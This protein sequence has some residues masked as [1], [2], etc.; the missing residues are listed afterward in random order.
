MEYKNKKMVKN[1]SKKNQELQEEVKK[2]KLLILKNKF[3][4][5]NNHNNSSRKHQKIAMQ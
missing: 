2:I 4:F 3:N 1:L 5:N